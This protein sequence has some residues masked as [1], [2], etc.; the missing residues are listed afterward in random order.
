[1]KVIKSEIIIKKT[2]QSGQYRI[3]V[4]AN[5]MTKAVEIHPRYK[6]IN[7]DDFIIEAKNHAK[8]II[9]DYSE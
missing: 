5:I 9:D 2:L 3:D 8:K 6:V 1:M 7:D 4:E